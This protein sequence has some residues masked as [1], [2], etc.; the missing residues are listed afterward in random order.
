[1]L[2][3]TYAERV[4]LSN[5]FQ[6]L[7]K[8]DP[9]NAADHKQS[10]EIIDSGYEALYGTAAANVFEESVPV[11]VCEEVHDILDMYRN[12]AFSCRDLGIEPEALGADFDGFDANAGTGHYGYAHFRRRDQGLWSELK[13]YPDNSH[14]SSSL[15]TYR[16]MLQRYR[17]VGKHIKLTEEEIKAITGR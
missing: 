10:Q 5:Q 9:D 2:K 6:I 15:P 16:S 13:G 14:S 11:E 12:F 7:A 8:L 4:I 3:L 17:T 1:M